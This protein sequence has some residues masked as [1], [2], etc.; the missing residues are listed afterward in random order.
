[1]IDKELIV[2]KEKFLKK[3]VREFRYVEDA[4]PTPEDLEEMRGYAEHGVVRGPDGI[5]Y[6]DSGSSSLYQKWDGKCWRRPR[7]RGLF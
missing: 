1:M 7:E 6:A 5:Y 4:D 2:A 3:L